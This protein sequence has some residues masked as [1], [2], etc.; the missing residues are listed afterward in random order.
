MKKFVRLP[1]V[2]N[3]NNVECSRLFYDQVKTRVRNLNRNK[4][5][6]FFINTF[7]NRKTS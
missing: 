1:A 6:R 3:S 5:V 2:E 4:H 7:I